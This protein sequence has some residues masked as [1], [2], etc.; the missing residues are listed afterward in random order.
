[1]QLFRG[2]PLKTRR[3]RRVPTGRAEVHAQLQE[4]TGRL[5]DLRRALS[6]ILPLL[7]R[8]P[9][10]TGFCKM[11]AAVTSGFWQCADMQSM[12]ITCCTCSAASSP[13][14]WITVCQFEL[15]LNPISHFSLQ[16]NAS[17]CIYA[18]LIVQ[19]PIFLI[20]LSW[21]ESWELQHEQNPALMYLL[22]QEPFDLTIYHFAVTKTISSSIER[23][24]PHTNTLCLQWL[25]KV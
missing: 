15:E 11:P 23:E 20:N 10:R 9:M 3:R 2:G 6:A 16:S 7:P 22:V 19:P 8:L 4:I 21:S 14:K 25:I 18:D 5:S 13:F 12:N 24:F 17:S 1:M